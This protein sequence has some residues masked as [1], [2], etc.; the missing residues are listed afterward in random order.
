MAV[1]NLNPLRRVRIPQTENQGYCQHKK[2]GTRHIPR[3]YFDSCCLQIPPVTSH[4]RFC[5]EIYSVAIP[6]NLCIIFEG[7]SRVLNRARTWSVLEIWASST[8]T[9]GHNGEETSTWQ[10]RQR[11]ETR[12]A[13]GEMLLDLIVTVFW[14]SCI[15]EEKYSNLLLIIR[16]CPSDASKIRMSK[17]NIRILWC[18]VTACTQ[19]LL[20]FVCWVI[21]QGVCTWVWKSY[22][23][24]L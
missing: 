16:C 12:G 24:L 21:S 15:A 7:W 2:S 23:V 6:V 4:S 1:S 5:S 8:H 18:G 13:Q 11:C 17:S 22:Q 9:R 19:F 10:L 20:Q 3:A 14:T